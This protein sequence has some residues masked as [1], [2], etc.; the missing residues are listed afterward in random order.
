M[1]IRSLVPY[2]LKI[3]KLISINMYFNKILHLQIKLVETNLP[4][5]WL[6]VITSRLDQ[7]RTISP[8]LK[9]MV[10]VDTS[11]LMLWLFSFEDTIV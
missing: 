2:I 8:C 4:I 5:A 11:L 7:F 6:L 9:A 10:I 3:T 1:D